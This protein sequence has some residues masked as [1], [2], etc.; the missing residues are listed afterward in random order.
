V[1]LEPKRIEAENVK[2]DL[3]QENRAAK[4]EQ[5]KK[6][7]VALRKEK[8]EAA[9]QKLRDMKTKGIRVFG[10]GVKSIGPMGIGVTA[11]IGS[12]VAPDLFAQTMQKN[13]IAEMETSNDFGTL[14]R[15]GMVATGEGV[16]KL[17][18]S[19]Y[20]GR[21]IASGVETAARIVDPGIELAGDFLAS[22]FLTKDAGEGSDYIK[23]VKPAVSQEEMMRPIQNPQLQAVADDERA[24]QEQMNM[25]NLT[26]NFRSEAERKSDLSLEDQMK[27]LQQQGGAN[28][29]R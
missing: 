24:V 15:K 12:V 18:D 4:I 7:S 29:A 23:D 11:A 9:K 1:E 5:N 6:E 13:K 19:D 2:K 10:S 8:V 27:I 25:Q 22:S 3:R 17:T 28:Y 16:S 14:L 20:T 21:E 26:Q